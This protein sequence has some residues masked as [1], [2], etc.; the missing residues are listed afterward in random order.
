MVYNDTTNKNGLLQHCEIITGL[1]DGAISGNTTLK[2]QFTGL[3]NR[4][5]HKVVTM[6]FAAQDDWDF[7]DPN[8]GNASNFPK[9]YNLTA[10]T[11]SVTLDVLTNK[12]LKIKRVEISYDGTTF[13]KAEPFDPGERGLSISTTA[14]ET[15]FITTEPKYDLQGNYIYLYPIPTSNVSNGLR[16]YYAR[17]IDEF[18]TSDTTQEPGI[19]EPFHPMISTDAAYQWLC[20]NDT[21]KAE[22]L[23]RDMLE[24][25]QRLKQYYGTKDED[26]KL[27]LSPAYVDYN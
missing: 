21:R 16:V 6:I 2:A 14:I 19:D 10:S 24:W 8:L 9:S 7:D 18:T 26:R 4:S 25:E 1:G 17:E 22:A 15:D 11:A 20:G 5:Y 12:I 13:Y 27:G 23:K 3:L